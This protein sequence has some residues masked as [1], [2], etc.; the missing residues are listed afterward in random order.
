MA[1]LLE[2][3]GKTTRRLSEDSVKADKVAVSATPTFKI[4][5]FRHAAMDA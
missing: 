2:L 5:E 4:P 1:K 3:Q